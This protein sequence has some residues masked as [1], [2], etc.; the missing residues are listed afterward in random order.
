MQITI[1]FEITLTDFADIVDA[2]G[3]AI[4]HWCDEAEYDEPYDENDPDATYTVSCEEGTQ[5]Y[6]LTK[7][8]IEKAMGLIAE[9]RMDV[10]ASIR[11]DI[12]QAITED[13]MGLIDGYAA[14]AIIQVACFGCIVYG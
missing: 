5:I 7:A 8:D 2:A 11:D 1:D 12:R 3:Y 13:D 9:D 4:G 10:S 6:T 14:D